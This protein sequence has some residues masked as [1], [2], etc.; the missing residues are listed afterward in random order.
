MREGRIQLSNIEP[1]RDYQKEKNP[2]GKEIRLAQAAG[3]A[4][5]KKKNYLLK[6]TR[7]VLRDWCC[8]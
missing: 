1:Q 8:A 6:P 4:N 2:V 3:C 5:A 7:I